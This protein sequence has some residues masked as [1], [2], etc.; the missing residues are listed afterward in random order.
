MADLKDIW[1]YPFNGASGHVAD[2]A[3]WSG[4]NSYGVDQRCNELL[5][6]TYKSW[7]NLDPVADLS[8]TSF[9][10]SSN[11]A[12][13][14]NYL[15][16]ELG[17]E[18]FSFYKI[19]RSPIVVATKKLIDSETVSSAT[20]ADPVVITTTNAHELEDGM[21]L[22]LAGFNGTMSQYNGN[23]LYAQ[24]I[25]N[26]AGTLNLSFDSAG[27]NLVGF[28]SPVTANYPALIMNVDTS[29]A[30]RFDSGG[31]VF[32]N[33]DQITINSVA[34][35]GQEAVG[36]TYYL[37]YHATNQY[38][39]FEDISLTNPLTAIELAPFDDTLTSV[40]FTNGN[41]GIVETSGALS[42]DQQL[43]FY[44]DDTNMP[45]N[46]LTTGIYFLKAT[47]V[48]TEY[49]LYTDY[50]R[51]QG[52]NLNTFEFNL[53]NTG[54]TFTID[55]N[56]LVGDFNNT[57]IQSEI[58]NPNAAFNTFNPYQ[59]NGLTHEFKL[60]YVAGSQYNPLLWDEGT[61]TW[62]AD[63]ITCDIVLDPKVIGWSTDYTDPINATMMVAG[64]TYKIY[65]V[66][67]TD[68]TLVGSPNNTVGTIFT[69]TG[70]AT[71][72]GQVY[73][74]SVVLDNSDIPTTVFDWYPNAAAG[75]GEVPLLI[76]NPTTDLSTL[77]DSRGQLVVQNYAYY[78]WNVAQWNKVNFGSADCLFVMVK[79]ARVN[80][81]TQNGS[82]AGGAYL[83]LKTRYRYDY[84]AY[85][86]SLDWRVTKE[87]IAEAFGI[88]VAQLGSS[89]KISVPRSVSDTTRT[90][91]GLG[92]NA[93]GADPTI[94]PGVNTSDWLYN[95]VGPS[96]SDT[97]VLEID[98][99][100]TSIDIPWN[101]ALLDTSTVN[102]TVGQTLT[103][104]TTGSI[105][106]ASTEPYK[107]EIDTVSIKMPGNK[108]YS[109]KD[110]GNSTVYAA[111]V[112]TTGYW[113][114][115][116]QSKTLYSA[117]GETAAQ[118]T[119]GVDASGYL[120]SI[121]LTEEVDAEGRYA[122]ADD[123][124]IPIQSPADLYIAPTPY[125]PDV[126]DTDDEWDSDGFNTNKVWPDHIRPI[127][128]KL[129]V[130][131][132]SSITR[133]QNGTK[134]VR[135]S[136]VVRH[137]LEVTYPPMTLANFRKFER[138]AQAA[139]GQATP[140]LF[141]LRYPNNENILMQRLDSDNALLPD[142]A[143]LRDT[144]VTG[145]KT[146]L[147]EGFLANQSNA[148]IQG[149]V[150]IFNIEDGNGGIV[151]VVNDV[152]SNIYGEAK[153]RLPY[154]TRTGRTAGTSILYKNPAWVVVTLA[155]GDF[156]YNVGTDSLYRLTV[157]FDFDE[158]K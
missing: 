12:R 79:M 138:T 122:D 75:Y 150:A 98:T 131:Q 119:V 146:M 140:F 152:D 91:I 50:T 86:T 155:D 7:P 88:T 23:T 132:P 25:D 80:D 71:G 4:D 37:K 94:T 72:T 70:P 40:T 78:Y 121:S 96:G 104:S 33:G 2:T 3:N 39:L 116:G 6:G 45:N 32:G 142:T 109:Y 55:S 99:S 18:N 52:V 20:A 83:E 60:D 141:K 136:G 143:R 30:I 130:Q 154:G 84:P 56:I 49:E 105:A 9:L 43:V 69:A 147:F 127:G 106:P 123:I 115:D 135:S 108:V 153:N 38:K 66:G 13:Y 157:R 133:S 101:I 103:D 26:T 110:A 53:D 85:Q 148:F 118:F 158:W 47:G 113:E 92:F 54:A 35:N 102:A 151:T 82:G 120:D 65:L 89:F 76:W 137:Q 149:E 74:Q 124:V 68:Y 61:S 90:A 29:D 14:K 8:Q 16:S 17:S 67:T 93:T 126:W 44:F 41:P 31:A 59:V 48:S 111:Q 100:T 21:L 58:Y 97:T 46:N 81:G 10:L 62:T 5:D 128:A 15:D 42:G 134:Y 156:E 36:N 19:Y 28:S 73:I 64:E 63:P 57:T 112:D 22:D 34:E 87:I 129:T 51:T 144:I 114:I 107:Y 117:T 125:A 11:I 27:S 24:V 139:R 145:D 77:E 1:N 95:L